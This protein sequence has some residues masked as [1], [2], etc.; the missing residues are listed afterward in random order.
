MNGFTVVSQYIL[1]NIARK[2]EYGFPEVV[3]QAP[4]TKENYLIICCEYNISL[5]ILYILCS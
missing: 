2:R 5:L 3:L 1:L 4:S